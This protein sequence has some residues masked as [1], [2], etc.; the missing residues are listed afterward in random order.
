MIRIEDI[1]KTYHMGAEV[2][3][4]LRGV[5]LEIAAGEMVAIVGA[6]GSGKSTLMH[7]LGCLD[8][9]DE[10]AYF[11]EGQNVAGLSRNRLAEV[12]NR[13]IG[14][15]F[16]TFNLLPRLTALENVELPLLYGGRRGA[17]RKAQAAMQRVGLADR[18][19]HRPSQLSGGQAQ[20]VAVARALVTDPAIVLADEPTGN[21][22]S[23][24]G[25]EI[26]QLIC[27]LNAEGRTVLIV[28]HDL[29]IAARCPRQVRLRDGMVV[30][31][32]ERS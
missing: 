2:V 29:S 3:R 4:A 7:I 11:L 15:V 16:Q 20:R 31:E 10:G 27:D 25:K 18:M 17:R 12:R 13:R 9:P 5:S 28:T 21:L 8:Q 24:T 1:H 26:L 6:S 14:F 30:E 32:E 23:A 19:R 22:D